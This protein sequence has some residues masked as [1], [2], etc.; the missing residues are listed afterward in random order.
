[1]S[2]SVAEFPRPSRLSTKVQI[3]LADDADRSAIYKL[4]HQ[5]YAL[6]LGQ[7]H[8]N[9]E[10]QLRDPLDEYNVYLKASVGEQIGGFV[11]VTPPGKSIR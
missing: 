11:S 10:R 2:T 9:V 5:I 8:P 1:M 6:E 7:H 4:R 3:A